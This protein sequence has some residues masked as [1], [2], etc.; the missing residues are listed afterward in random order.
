[1]G[2]WVEGSYYNEATM[3]WNNVTGFAENV[4]IRQGEPHL[5]VTTE[6]GKDLLPVTRVERIYPDLF[7]SSINELNRDMVTGQNLSLIGRVVMAITREQGIGKEV[8]RATGFVEGKVERIGFDEYGN[9]VLIVGGKEVLAR[10]VFSV[11]DNNRLLGKPIA[12]MVAGAKPTDEPVEVY[13]DIEGV[14]MVRGETAEDDYMELLI[15]GGHKAVVTNLSR[16]AD[17][18]EFNA[19]PVAYGTISGTVDRVQLV[20]GQPFLIVGEYEQV[21]KKDADGE[22]LLDQNGQ[23]IME[24]VFAQTGRILFESYLKARGNVPPATTTP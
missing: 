19:R 23:Q 16:I 15:S 4:V 11:S 14:R 3:T 18:L 22:L 12:A 20:A 9:P 7:L 24:T 10:E 17:A 21:P 5:S 13:G 1:L 8:G 6:N 2:K